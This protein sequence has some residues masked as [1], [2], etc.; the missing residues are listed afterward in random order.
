MAGPEARVLVVDD[1][2]VTLDYLGRTLRGFGYVVQTALAVAPALELLA[3]DRFDLV[4]TDLRMPGASGLD[5]LHHV[6]EKLPTT[7]V[8]MITGYASIEGAVEAVKAGAEDYLAKPF[9][10]EELHASVKRALSR[11]VAVPAR[12]GGAA[13]RL[14]LIGVSEVMDRFCAALERAVEGEAPLLLLGESGSGR[15]AAARAVAR[16]RGGSS[17]LLVTIECADVGGSSPAEVRAL[18]GEHPVCLCGLEVASHEAQEVVRRMVARAARSRAV[19]IVCASMDLP[20][21]AREGVIR[22]D[23]W[24]TLASPL[25]VPP[26][27]ERGEDVLLLAEH[28]LGTL[29]HEIGGPPGRITAE[30]SR[31]LLAYQWPGNIVELRS[32]IAVAIARSRGATLE[33]AGLPPRIAAVPDQPAQRTLAEAES[34]H[35]KRVLDA[36]GGNKTRAAAVLGIDRKTL[37]TKLKALD[38]A[39]DLDR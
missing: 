33:L 18:L 15:S 6:R 25:V 8:M 28:F 22:P 27:R 31:A 10:D 16:A 24:E 7:A 11:V 20:L 32:V 3:S 4:I 1:S 5:L 13:A 17:R 39:T 21:L 19:L 34:E 36:V 23:L 12:A 30:A 29:A 2:E 37:R 35:I 38:L 9:T 26:L 14:G